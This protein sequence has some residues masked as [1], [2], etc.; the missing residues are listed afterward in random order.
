MSPHNLEWCCPRWGSLPNGDCI[1]LGLSGP[2]P[3]AS[4]GGCLHC[5]NLDYGPES[6][7]P[8]GPFFPF[9]ARQQTRPAF[10][11]QVPS[12]PPSVQAGGFLLAWLIRSVL[13]THTHHFTKHSSTHL[14]CLPNAFSY[15]LYCGQAETFLNMLVP[16]CLTIVFKS[17]FPPCTLWQA[18]RRNQ[19]AVSTLCLENSPAKYPVPP[20][21]SPTLQ[22]S[23]F[24]VSCGLRL[25][26]FFC[27]YA[28]LWGHVGVQ[29]LC[30]RPLFSS[31]F[32]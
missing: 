28:W 23:D 29:R 24:S 10:L 1:S 2:T 6:E 3:A 30:C 22:R 13:L 11:C 5:W 14:C 21:L 17:F 4:V 16:F 27:D 26:T 7:M 19:T 12:L 8:S 32:F 20:L 9:L 31:F 15:F 18:V 25:R